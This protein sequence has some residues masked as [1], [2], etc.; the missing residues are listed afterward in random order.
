[1][2]IRP[3]SPTRRTVLAGGAAAGALSLTS[4]CTSVRRVVDGEFAALYP[5]PDKV[6]KVG[7]VG[8]GGRG[9][10]AALQA[11][12]AEEGTVQLWSI[13]DALPERIDSCLAGLEGALG[14]EQADRLNVAEERRHTG[15]DAYRKVIDSGVDV[16]LLCTP[17]GFRPQ[18]LAY[19]VDAKKHVFA[20]KP[21]AVDVPGVRSVMDSAAKAQTQ[22]T[23]LVAGFC[24]RYKAGHRALYKELLAGAIGDVHAVHTNYNTGWIGT[25]ERQEGW[26]DVEWQLRNWHHF[27]WLSGHH[28]TEQACHSLDMQAWAFG[29][30]TPLSV[31][32]TG[33]QS[34][35]SGKLAGNCF[36]NFSAVFEY[37]DGAKGFHMCRQW[38]N[39]DGEN[40]DY[41]FGNAG[42]GVLENWTPRYEL[43]GKETWV[44]EGEHNDMYQTEHD[45][46]FASIRN[47]RPIN[48]GKRMSTSTMLSVMTRIAATTGRKITW[49]QAMQSEERLG[50]DVVDF[51]SYTPNPVAV[52]GKTPFA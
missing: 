43:I 3:S 25:H 39:S 35:R 17:P 34:T 51:G 21:M 28:V 26:S 5:A 4:G 52:P 41:F 30:S 12:L 37:E 9:T 42:R 32:A 44:Y 15:F 33:G 47:A 45:E 2:P 27:D 23:A 18:Q 10:G 50:P 29:D 20:E 16:V 46:L 48:D 11:M 40:N 7:L 49:E 6:L 36:D 38:A 24:W 8:C 14:E 19:A 13:G 22:G 1:M 31:V